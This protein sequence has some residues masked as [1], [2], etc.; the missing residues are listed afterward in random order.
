MNIIVSQNVNITHIVNGKL[1]DAYVRVTSS[2]TKEHHA[3]NLERMNM[4]LMCLTNSIFYF[5]ND[6]EVE[7]HEEEGKYTISSQ[8]FTLTFSKPLA[9]KIPFIKASAEDKYSCICCS[10]ESWLTDILPMAF[11]D[12]EIT[13]LDNPHADVLE[14]IF[15]HSTVQTPAKHLALVYII[16]LDSSMHSHWLSTDKEEYKG[17]T[18][19]IIQDIVPG[20]DPILDIGL[21]PEQGIVRHVGVGTLDYTVLEEFF[22]NEAFF[23]N[24]YIGK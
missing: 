12:L 17:Q 20:C 5:D 21:S 3:S 14:N 4:A 8:H 2:G 24:Q 6:D 11:A 1:T 18:I 23:A 16:E 19:F 13:I 9:R 10:V 7:E 15:G 22:N